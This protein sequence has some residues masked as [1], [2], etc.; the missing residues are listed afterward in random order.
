MKHKK[1][2]QHESLRDGLQQIFRQPPSNFYHQ[3]VLHINCHGQIEVEHCK[4]IL[5]YNEQMIRLD[6]GRWEITLMGDE[7]QLCAISK[8]LLA[9]KGRVLKTEFTYKE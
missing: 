7:L 9:L 4:S 1:P 6:M 8:A 2:K 3:P 5:F